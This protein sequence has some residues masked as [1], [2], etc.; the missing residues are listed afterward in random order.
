MD[1]PMGNVKA[2]NVCQLWVISDDPR[3]LRKYFA[4]GLFEGHLIFIASANLE[5]YTE[6]GGVGRQEGEATCDEG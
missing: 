3:R 6:G 1:N 2:A 4:S 5:T